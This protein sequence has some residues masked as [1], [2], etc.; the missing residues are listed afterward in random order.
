MNRLVRDSA[1]SGL[2]L[3]VYKSCTNKL[4]KNVDIQGYTDFLSLPLLVLCKLGLHDGHYSMKS[5]I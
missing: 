2:L 3:S 4:L 5:G 1:M